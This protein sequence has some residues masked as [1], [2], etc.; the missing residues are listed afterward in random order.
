[1]SLL[2]P[3][4]GHPSFPTSQQSKVCLPHTS[5]PATNIAH[6]PDPA[7][8][9]HED[10]D[11]HFSHFSCILLVLEPSGASYHSKTPFLFPFLA[12]ATSCKE[13]ISLSFTLPQVEVSGTRVGCSPSVG[14]F[15]ILVDLL[16]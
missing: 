12:A 13:G 16:G 15:L 3:P 7:S 8:P 2:Y 6:Q 5:L 11:P 14:P 9:G 1:M 4:W 10:W